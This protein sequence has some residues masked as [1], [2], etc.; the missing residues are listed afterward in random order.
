VAAFFDPL[1][2][3]F[4]DADAP[5]GAAIELQALEAQ[6][7]LLPYALAFFAV[8]LPILAWAG[9]FADNAVWMSALFAQFAVNWAA[10]YV[11]VT[12]MRQRP[13]IARDTATRTRIHILGGLMWAAAVAQLAAF[14]LS[15][16]PASETILMMG[17]GAAC[18]LFFFTCPSL[19]NLLV[20]GPAAA[21]PPLVALCRV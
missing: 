20:V 16:G 18:V 5:P 11:V 15:A 6:Q 19:A 3:L 7:A 2:D 12:W 1:T 13:D 14:G 4:H 21:L 10:F 9:S 8:S 17:V